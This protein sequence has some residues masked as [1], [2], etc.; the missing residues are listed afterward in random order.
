MAWAAARDEAIKPLILEQLCTTRPA[1]LPPIG[2][3]RLSQFRHSAHITDSSQPAQELKSK[4][5]LFTIK[6]SPFLAVGLKCFPILLFQVLPKTR[7]QIEEERGK[8]GEEVGKQVAMGEGRAGA[9]IP[10]EERRGKQGGE[11]LQEEDSSHSVPFSSWQQP[12]PQQMS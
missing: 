1:A 8:R 4:G 7:G 9:G 2:I 6:F 12:M 5:M 11:E 10:R 3:T